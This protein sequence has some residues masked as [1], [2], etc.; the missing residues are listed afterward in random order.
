MAGRVGTAVRSAGDFYALS[1]DALTGLVTGPWRWQEFVDQYWFIARVSLVPT[2]LMVLPFTVLVVFTLNS[3][4]GEIGASD[5]AGA[6]AGLGAVTQIG[7]LV[8]VLVVAG[9]GATA[10][11]ADLGS[12]TI[13][14]EISALEV[15][16]LDP[17]T[18]LVLPRALAS[19]LVAA[20]LNAAVCAI[21]L[22]GGF[23][24]SVYLNHV[25]PGAFASGVTLLV[26]PGE[27]ILSEA[28]AALF[29]LIAGLVACYRGLAVA[30]SG[31]ALTESL[32]YLATFPFPLD[33]YRNAVRG[34]YANGTV[35]LDLRLP[36]LDRGL[37][38]GTPFEGSLAAL[39]TVLGVP[40]P[41][42]EPPR[43]FL[44]DALVPPVP[45]VPPVQAAQ[46]ED[47]QTDDGGTHG[48]EGQGG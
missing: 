4:L 7:P 42:V 31:D 46:A 47:A 2:V 25:D 18:H 15:L 45:P 5:M 9:T 41:Y 23:F 14:D 21:G 12:R 19:A 38:I 10:V 26:G 17:A 40:A 43:E 39:D 13:R 11:A 22:A 32:R 29:G 8:T 24:F 16:G 1:A 28:K 30:D 3:L 33:N 37:L 36:V 34:D 35:I 27:L 44:A 20:T 6:G 48:G